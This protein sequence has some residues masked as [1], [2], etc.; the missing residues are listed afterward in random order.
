ML[1]KRIKNPHARVEMI[2]FLV[3]LVP[4]SASNRGGKQRQQR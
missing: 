2:K 1:N 4:Q 3:Y